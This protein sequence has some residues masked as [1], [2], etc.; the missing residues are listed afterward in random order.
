MFWEMA[1]E[2]N[3][4]PHIEQKCAIWTEAGGSLQDH[5]FVERTAHDAHTGLQR[6]HIMRHFAIEIRTDEQH[7]AHIEHFLTRKC[8]LCGVSVRHYA[9]ICGAFR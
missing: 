2:Q 3:F 7:V 4:G 1:I 9:K 6:P 8:E 5:A